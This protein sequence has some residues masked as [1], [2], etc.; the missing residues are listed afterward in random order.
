MSRFTVVLQFVFAAFVQFCMIHAQSDTRSVTSQ[1]ERC[2]M[3]M[4][5]VDRTIR[6]YEDIIEKQKQFIDNNNSI[7]SDNSSAEVLYMENKLEYFNNRAG[8]ARNQSDKIREELR[9]VSGPSC[10][11]CIESS[12]N[13]YCR[14]AEALLS[15]INEHI[16]KAGNKSIQGNDSYGSVSE[17]KHANGLRKGF[18]LR[19]AALDS[20]KIAVTESLSSCADKSASVL[21]RQA[22]AAVVR[23][24]SLVLNVHDTAAANSNIN[25]A[26]TLFRKAA[27]KCGPH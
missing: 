13:L 26:E 15:E 10:P 21:H 24:D 7:K 25:I 16:A 22:M 14:N 9:N 18:A 1:F 2:S 8:R 27:Q 17:D 20:L 19:R 23:A 12:V 11:S 5:R 6:R 3:V 4:D